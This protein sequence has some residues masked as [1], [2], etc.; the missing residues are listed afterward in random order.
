M[1]MVWNVDVFARMFCS[2][3]SSLH[4]LKSMQKFHQFFYFSPMKKL[5]FFIYDGRVFDTK[6]LKGFVVFSGLILWMK[7]LM[8]ES[9]KSYWNE[10]ENVWYYE[11]NAPCDLFKLLNQNSPLW[12]FKRSPEMKK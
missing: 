2:L 5:I 6:L 1:K 3:K 9:L 10:C 7:S 11:K 8:L 12:G 4:R